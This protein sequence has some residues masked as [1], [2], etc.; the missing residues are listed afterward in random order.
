MSGSATFPALGTT[1]QVDS[2][3]DIDA[4]VA[5][6]REVVGAID[7]ACSRFRD[8]SEL[9]MVNRAGGRPV[10]ISGLL[11]AAVRVALLAAQRTGGVVDP[12]VGASVRA[13]GYDVSFEQL[14]SARP[15]VRLTCAPGWRCVELGD[16]VVRVPDGV[17]LDLGATAK[18]FAADLAARR[19]AAASG[20]GV[21]VSLGGDIAVAGDPPAGGWPVGIADSHHVRFADADEMVDVHFGGLATS[22]T[23]VRRWSA[24]ART[25]HHIVDPRA[26]RSAASGWRTVSVAA[27]SCVAANTLTT[28][29]IVGGPGVLDATSCP[30]RAVADG[31]AVLRGNGSPEPV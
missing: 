20:G 25:R 7:A 17:Q 18:A 22:S 16:G 31:G 5:A 8:D 4:A 19:A 30:F 15:T 1:A 29:A 9:A 24:G 12:T 10:A 11:T 3:G 23:T 13:V 28:W 14:Q 26:G 2:L 21:L 27:E 6:V